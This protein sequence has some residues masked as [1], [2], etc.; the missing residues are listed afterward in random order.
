MKLG[1]TF[2]HA[3]SSRRTV[4]WSFSCILCLG[5]YC[6]PLA[7]WMLT[8]VLGSTLLYLSLDNHDFTNSFS[9]VGLGI[10]VL[11]AFCYHFVLPLS[12]LW[13]EAPEPRARI[14][15]EVYRKYAVSSCRDFH[16]VNKGGGVWDVCACT[17]TCT[18]IISTSESKPDLRQFEK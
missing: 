6:L 1:T 2:P 14:I 15:Q 3:P 7:H 5:S 13:A 12:L 18:N 8:E 17:H 11:W 9:E 10:A 4:A 16:S